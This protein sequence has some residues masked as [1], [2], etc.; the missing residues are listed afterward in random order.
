MTKRQQYA[1]GYRVQTDARRKIWKERKTVVVT[2]KTH[3]LLMA[4]A[5]SNN[6]P[7]RDATEKLIGI[8]YAT[9][10]GIPIADM[11]LDRPLGLKNHKK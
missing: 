6:L 10:K 2:K 9:A 11:H 7:L 5:M 1:A 4:F 3:L 8:G